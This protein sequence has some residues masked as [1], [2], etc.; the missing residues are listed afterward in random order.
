[1]VGR[2][3]TN[4]LKFSTLVGFVCLFPLLSCVF[5]SP[6]PN[7][8]FDYKK[9]PC[10]DA[11]LST[12]QRVSDLL[13][14][15]TLQEKI[16]QMVDEA[17]AIERLGIPAYNWWSECLHGLM[18]TDV[19]VFP[20]AIG[21]ASTWNP[22]LVFEIT[23]AISD[24]ARALNR[25]G[26]K[27]RRV[28]GLT[29]WSP[30][31]NIARD[32]RWGRTQETYGEDPYLTSKIAVAF[33]KGLQGNDP[34][35]LKLVSTPKHFIA[36]NLEYARHNGSSDVDEQLLREYYLPAFKA[37]VTE[38]R[39]HSVM[40]AYNALNKIPCCSDR[41]LITGI[42]R[43]EWGF[44]GYVVS[45]CGAIEDIYADHKYLATAEEATAAG[46]PHTAMTA[47]AGFLR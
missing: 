12:E 39:A 22:E 32:P 26:T 34:K 24:E 16:S 11:N 7:K 28:G 19:T 9:Y 35:Y 29:Y 40:C 4:I 5:G 27:D 45:D 25:K 6:E 10:F 33:V 3:Q 23:T 47:S 42:L 15:M 2:G 30:T 13:G 20:Q 46:L 1:M 38:A 44:D 18:A 14:R 21:L 17:A 36:N 8:T 31:I 43:N 37:C 41:R